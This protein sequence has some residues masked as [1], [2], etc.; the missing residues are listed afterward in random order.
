MSQMTMSRQRSPGRLLMVGSLLLLLSGCT[1]SKDEAVRRLQARSLYEQA[2]KS[3]GDRQISLGL[4]SL[5]E[6][7]QFDPGNP[8]FRNTLG[9][10]LLDLRKPA[11]AATEFRKAVELDPSYA[12]AA[13]N[14]GLSYAEQGRYEEAIT[15]Y[16]KAL[17]LPIYS[18]P[19]VAHYNLGRAYSQTGRPREAEEALRTAIH[20][21]PTLGPA[22]YQLGVVLSTLGRREEAK[23]AFLKARD[24]EPTSPFG[25]AATEA[26]K[27]LGEGG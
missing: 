8:I 15:A 9:V 18:T 13:H 16:K 23:G 7:V 5:R 21:D 11:E 26:L 25:Q 22:Y 12:E 4:S 17:S 2:L 20:L 6:A 3:L 27:T 1:S 10:V 19:E 24:L 14:L